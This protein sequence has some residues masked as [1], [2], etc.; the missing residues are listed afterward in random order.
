[1]F[2]R[3]LKKRAKFATGETV[4][5]KS[6]DNISRLLDSSNKTDGCLFMPQMWHYCGVTQTVLKVV[7][8]FHNERLVADFRTKTRLYI[9]AD[10]LCDGKVDNFPYEC[11]H[12][13]FL[14]WHEEWL[15]K[16]Q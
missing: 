12:T 11:D 8:N 3:K 6:R 10:V 15:D 7:N 2:F 9:L 4:R 16:V 1:M 13:C 5:V 14:L